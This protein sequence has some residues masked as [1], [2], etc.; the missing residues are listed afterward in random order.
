MVKKKNGSGIYYIIFAWAFLL[1]AMY[2]AVFSYA[3]F[4]VGLGIISL[5]LSYIYR[6]KVKINNPLMAMNEYLSLIFLS[7]AIFRILSF[8]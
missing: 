2:M 5:V 6:M 4:A 3:I 7:Y 8:D 1:V